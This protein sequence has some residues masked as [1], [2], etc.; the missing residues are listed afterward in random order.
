MRVAETAVIDFD[1]ID[2]W[3]SKMANALMAHLPRD[4]ESKLLEARP[5]YI[6]SASNR[7][8]DLAGRDT[9]IDATLTWLRSETVSGYHGTRLTEA[10]VTSI[11]AVGLVP[12]RAETRRDRVVMRCASCRPIM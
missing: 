10:E 12:L 8:F 11:R 5:K 6:E 3:A 4:I 9:I 7:L 2:D 1:N